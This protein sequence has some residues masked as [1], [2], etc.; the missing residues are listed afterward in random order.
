M[1]NFS[2]SELRVR[3]GP[4]DGCG[5]SLVGG[6]TTLGREST[7]DIV[8]EQPV[9][10]R[11]HARIFFN[12]QSYWIQDLGSQNGTSVDGLGIGQ[13]PRSLKNGERIQLGSAATGTVW[14]FSEA[15]GDVPSLES[16][17]TMQISVGPDAPSQAPAATEQL[18]LS[19]AARTQ[20]GTSACAA[21]TKN[22][23]GSWTCKTFIAFDTPGHQIEVSRGTTF[24]L[25]N[26]FMGFDLAEWLNENCA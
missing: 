19:G 17:P 3:G 6:I 14:E 9:V 15:Q 16:P 1:M 4:F 10:S 22:L 13:E 5:I 25:G 12:A 2:R 7:N 23:N 18:G 24:V 20:E 26:E 11:N 21:F 8:V